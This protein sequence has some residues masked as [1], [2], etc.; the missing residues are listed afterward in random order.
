MH[1]YK[2]RRK[3]CYVTPCGRRLRNFEEVHKYL[4]ITK[5]NMEMDFFSF[6]WRLRVL[7]EFKVA[8]EI[9]IKDISQ[10]K[11][12]VKISAIN[13]VDNDYIEHIEYSTHRLPQEGVNINS[14]P[15][16]LIFCDCQDDCAD[17]KKCACRQL[18]IQSI[19]CEKDNVA[20]NDVGYEYRRLQVCKF[21]K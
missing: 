4:T 1:S 10:A 20:K 5:L 9:Q 17:K 18:T 6:E 19:K 16:F 12:H 2:G 21:I 15:E 3:V 13:T 7:D 14:D 8:K 11:Q